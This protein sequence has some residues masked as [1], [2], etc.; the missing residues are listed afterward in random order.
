[1][2]GKKMG[3]LMETAKKDDL[4]FVRELLSVGRIKPVI[5]RVYGLSGVPDALPR[6]GSR[7][8]KDVDRAM[9]DGD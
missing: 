9:A 6:K 5:D 2:S 1:M 7:A 4:V 8:R 3:N